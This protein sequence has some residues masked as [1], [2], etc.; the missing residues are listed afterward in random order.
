MTLDD[1]PS[2]ALFARVAQFHSFSAAARASGIAKSAVSKRVT[3]L[4]R[5]LGV[6]LLTR[7]TRTLSLTSYSR[8][9]LEVLATLSPSPL[10]ARN[11]STSRRVSGVGF[12]PWRPWP[13]K[14][15]TPGVLRM[16]Y[17]ELSSMTQRTSR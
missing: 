8:R 7:T 14:P 5:R 16:T 2:M 6:R 13:T 15:V 4:E 1:L 3:L 11:V 12:W 9:G 17:Q 10:A